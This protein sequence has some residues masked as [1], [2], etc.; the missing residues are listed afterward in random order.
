MA[1]TLDPRRERHARTNRQRRNKMKN[2]A[3]KIKVFT[4]ISRTTRTEQHRRSSRQIQRK[5]RTALTSVA[6]ADHGGDPNMPVFDIR[7]KQ[8]VKRTA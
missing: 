4:S 1:P 6:R 7:L 8:F 2:G 3:K 5:N